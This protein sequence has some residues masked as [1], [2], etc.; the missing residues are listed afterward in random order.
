MKLNNLSIIVIKNLLVILLLSEVSLY[1]KNG[2]YINVAGNKISI[3]NNYIERVITFQGNRASTTQI[4]NKLS[5][6]FY[7]V[8][9]DEFALRVI[10]SVTGPAFSKNQNGEEPVV[11]TSGDFKFDGYKTTNLNQDG[12]ELTLKFEFNC[13]F[14]AFRVKVNYEVYPN[15]FYMRKFIEIS[16]TSFGMQFLDKIFLESITFEQKE[17]SH[18]QFGQPVFN[19]NIFLGVEYPTAENT[20]DA[21]KVTVGYIVGKNITKDIYTS[22]TAVLGVS[23]SSAKLEQ[24]FMNYVDKLKVKGTRPFLLYNT[25]YDLKRTRQADGPES[26]MNETNVLKRIDTLKKYFNKYNIHLNSVVLD[27]GWDNLHSMWEIDSTRFPNGFTPLVSALKKMHS[28]LGLWTSPFGGYKL[29]EIRVD[30]ARKHGYEIDGDGFCLAGTKY[31]TA[32]KKAMTDFTKEYNV[33][34]FKWDGFLYACNQLNHGHLPGI[35]SREAIVS[36]YIDLMKSV[37]KINPDIFLNITSDTWLSPWW[38][39]YADCIWMQGRDFAY[40]KDVPCIN[41]RDKA[42]TYKDG[43]LWDDFQKKHLLFPM[44]SIMTHGIIKGQ[45]NL[46]GGKNESFDSFCNEVMMYFGRGVMMWELYVTPDLLSNKDWSAIADAVKWAKANKNVLKKTKMILGNPLK[47]EVYGYLHMTKGKGI[48]VLR[49]PDVNEHDAEF[50]FSGNLGNID[51]LTDYYVKVIYPYNYIFPLTVKLNDK[52]NI[53]L[54]GYEILTAELIPSKKIDKNL[55]VGVKYSI[56]NNTIT[57]YGETGSKEKIESINKGK[58]AEVNF[59]GKPR[60]ININKNVFA[61]RNN[62]LNAI[63][64]VNVPANYKNVRIGFLLEPSSSVKGISLPHAKIL[65]NGI[66]TKVNV[67][68]QNGNWFW[69]TADLVSAGNKI[70]CKINL[71]KNVNWKTST[72]LFAAEQLSGKTFGQKQISKDNILPD[73]PYPSNINHVIVPLNRGTE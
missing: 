28:S 40:V 24:T 22:H 36:A 64:N 29:R 32:L 5:G 3:G 56:N 50:T 38:L 70:S 55:P 18:G 13:E 26:I 73:E 27:E 23:V 62:E 4:F 17:F 52:I 8:N 60:K 57:V 53:P 66:Q 12:K 45:L 10:F 48:L 47:R 41:E 51:P 72:W 37:R 16:D 31:K 2:A 59:S 68:Q 49:N 71:D 30:W 19:K 67:V 61:I 42:I 63:Y 69:M 58:I 44:S 35:Y 43:V 14:T 1:A 21:G 65:I 7:N 39:Q 15:N 34:Y 9:A 11:L 46:L 20:I 25:W 54:T 33:G 6:T